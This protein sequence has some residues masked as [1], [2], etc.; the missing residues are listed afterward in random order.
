MASE[1]SIKPIDK[2][3]DSNTYFQSMIFANGTTIVDKNWY[4]LVTK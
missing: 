3:G 2:V 1:I 4:G